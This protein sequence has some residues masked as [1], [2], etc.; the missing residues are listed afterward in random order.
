MITDG[1]KQ[2]YLFVKNLNSLLKK[3]YACSENYCLIC[4]KAFRIKSSFQ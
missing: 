2:D 1:Q 4:L 3:T